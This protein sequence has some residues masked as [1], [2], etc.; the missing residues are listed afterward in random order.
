[1]KLSRLSGVLVM[2]SMPA[3]AVFNGGI[4]ANLTDVNGAASHGYGVHLGYTPLPYLGAEI[5]IDRLGDDYRSGYK[6]TYDTVSFKVKPRYQFATFT[7]YGNLGFHVFTG[8]ADIDAQ[9]VYGLGAETYLHQRATIGAEYNFYKIGVSDIE[10]LT[11]KLSYL[12]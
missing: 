4:N 7:M 5:G 8:E 9:F 11:V 12:F 10:A 6:T 2:L 3:H 1:M